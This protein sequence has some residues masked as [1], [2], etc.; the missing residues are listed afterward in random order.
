M[1]AETLRDG[2]I[3]PEI[4]RFLQETVIQCSTIASPHERATVFA[5]ELV[6]NG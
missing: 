3:E 1:R 5:G 4:E 6:K 2:R